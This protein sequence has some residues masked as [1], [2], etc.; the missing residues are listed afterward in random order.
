MASDV[1]GVLYV[2]DQIF[3]VTQMVGCC[4]PH[5]TRLDGHFRSGDLG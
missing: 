2:Q 5:G 4:L 1:R 3:T